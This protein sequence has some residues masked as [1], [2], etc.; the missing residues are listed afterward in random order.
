MNC[1]ICQA[2]P[3]TQDDAL[4]ISSGTKR[5][6]LCGSGNCTRAFFKAHEPNDKKAFP[7]TAD[8]CG[9]CENHPIVATVRERTHRPVGLCARCTVAFFFDKS[10]L[11]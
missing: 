4:T 8:I 9:G 2:G 3:L 6:I 10:G 11:H 7:P 1:E 5:H